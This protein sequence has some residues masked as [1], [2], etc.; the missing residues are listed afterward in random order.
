MKRVVI[1]VFDSFGIGC[2]DDAAKF[3]D[4]GSNT[5]GHIAKAC[6]EGAADRDGLRKGPLQIPYLESLGLSNAA[7]ASCKRKLP[8]LNT[9]ANPRGAYG[10][11]Q[12]IS[13]GKDTPSGHWEICGVPVLFEWGYFPPDYPS[14]PAALTEA[15]I[16]E[17]KIPGI[18]GNCHASGTVIIDEL[19]EE[20]MR[21]GKPIVYTSADSVFQIAAHEESFGL[22]R[23]Y[24]ISHVARKL[25][26]PYNI[27][28]VIA[29]PFVGKPGEFRRTG[30]RHDYAVPPPGETLLDNL[31]K[32]GGEVISIG[33]I[34]DIF[35]HRGISKAVKATGLA[36]LFDTTLK[37]LNTAKDKTIVFTNFVDFDSEYGHRRDVT[38]Y[39][40]GLEYLDKRLPELEKALTPGDIVLITADHGCDPTWPGTDHTREHIPALFFGPAITG[41]FIGKRNTFA[42]LGQ[43]IASYLQIEPLAYGTSFINP[44]G[45]VEYS[46]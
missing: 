16:K 34:A 46:L 25:V 19:G 13:H 1:L 2:S 8:G 18:L 33:K 40:N 17:A 23:L 5:L 41:G 21:T 26:D 43:S 32:S 29:R 36:E 28:R 14:F 7:E 12:E 37:E 15:F 31:I 11:A 39:A 35:A 30:N 42:D 3:K 22:E 27:G 20:H 44:E 9:Q 38:G 45:K 6:F 4:V 10:F 24:E